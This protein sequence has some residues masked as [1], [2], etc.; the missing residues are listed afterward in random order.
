MVLSLQVCLTAA[1][2]FGV[3]LLGANVHWQGRNPYE[4][5]SV[6]KVLVTTMCLEIVVACVSFVAWVW[7]V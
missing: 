7:G 4:L 5:T 6:D 2:A 1:A 3:T